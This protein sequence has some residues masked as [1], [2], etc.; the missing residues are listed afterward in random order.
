MK[1]ATTAP[2]AVD[3]KKRGPF[4]APL[5]AEVCA[6][7]GETHFLVWH[8]Q[9]PTLD[10]PEH[11]PGFWSTT[12]DG[13]VVEVAMKKRLSD[14]SAK[15]TRWYRLAF[16][17]IKAARE[18]E[19]ARLRAGHG[20]YLGDA[21]R[22]ATRVLV[23][24]PEY[25]GRFAHT[26]PL[27]ILTVD[28]EQRSSGGMFP[29]R[30]APLVSIAL[31]RA[32]GTRPRV[33]LAVCS[34]CGK[35]P[36]RG[37]SCENAEPDDRPLIA[38]WKRA[39]E[40][41]D[42]DIIAAFNAPFDL[43]VLAVRGAVHGYRIEDW[44]RIIPATGERAP[45]MPYDST[46][47][48]RRLYVGGRLV[49]DVYQNANPKTDYN[50]SGIKDEKLKTVGKWLGLPVIEEDTSETL[51]AWRSRPLKLAAYNANDVL[52]LEHLV[53][54]YLPDR[55]GLAEFYGATLDMCL[56]APSGWGG[57]VASARALYSAGIVSD[58]TN[59]DRHREWLKGK[60]REDPDPDDEDNGV[61]Q[62][63]GAHIAIYQTGLFAPIHKVDFA[64]LYP[65]V[66][67]AT[68]A[69]PDNTRIVGTEPLGP[70]HTEW[71]GDTVTVHMPDTNYGHSW[72]IEIRGESVF[73]PILRARM[74]ER[75]AAKHAGDG[76]RAN[77]L[78]TQL[79]AMFGCQASLFN[80]YG[81]YPVAIMA[82]G[83]ARELIKA[84]EEP[85]G[86]SK[87]ETD[88]DGVYCT[89]RFDEKKLSA[90]A[91]R[92]AK[93]HGFAPVFEVEAEEY[94]A[95]YF[96]AMK[97][98]IL[99]SQDGKRI[100]RTGTAM[101]GKSHPAIFDHIMEGVGRVLLTEGRDAAL[102]VARE[103]LDLAKYGPRDFVQRCRMGQPIEAYAHATKE[104]KVALAYQETFGVP[105]TV[106]V[107][108]EYVRTPEGLMPPTPENLSRLDE[109]AYLSRVCLPALARL[110]FS[111]LKELGVAERVK[112][113]KA[114]SKRRAKHAKR[115]GTKAPRET[116]LFNF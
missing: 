87:I 51:E 73:T 42:P 3:W 61:R 107:S 25:F 77:I 96:H 108:Y 83:Y 49:W 104:T 29:P 39:L 89:R 22:W 20:R 9:A 17:S 7:R 102:K 103:K 36:K 106:G 71:K 84:I 10:K 115:G 16:P 78:K 32:D 41:Y 88:T 2:P 40:V 62:F 58:G 48:E 82:A 8:D 33:L 28:I 34:A 11:R 99:L 37:C 18:Y 53:A 65:R 13:E 57:T 19:E 80:R 56:S 114:R 79:N 31:G 76:V 93:A 97:A 24:H 100:K 68:R 1:P 12:P 54:R 109:H 27:R 94:P 95:G 101:K 113:L 66:L 26:K 23:E 60:T 116:S 50:L 90:V 75:L 6:I 72:L 43:G 15:P 35:V 4:R 47:N 74:K 64:S 44:G 55:L 21:D 38:A 45:S 86:D 85:L 112:L 30:D 46:F 91:N 81:V 92:V 14:T 105:P 70:F 59:F 63:A 111:D 98:Y 52:L 110:G 5:K 67:E 69:G